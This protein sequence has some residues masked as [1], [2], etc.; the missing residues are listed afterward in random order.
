MAYR[1]ASCNQLHDEQPMAFHAMAP[2][3]WDTLT[4]A[5]QAARGELGSDQCVIDEKHFFIRGLIHIPVHGLEEP[6]VWGVWVSLSLKSFLRA[7]E[8]WTTPGREAEPPY[9][10]WLSTDLAPRYPSTLQLKTM[11]QT[12]EVGL[13]PLITLEPTDHPLAVEQREGISRQRLEALWAS[14]LHG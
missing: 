10:G 2:L 5:E 13:R 12:R 3:I 11:V 14:L 6:L 7:S 8:L 9:F 1:C 4:K